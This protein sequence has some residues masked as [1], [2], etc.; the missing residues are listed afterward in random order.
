MALKPNV[1]LKATDKHQLKLVTSPP[2]QAQPGPTEALVHVRATGV[3]G[4]D[5]H[6]WQHGPMQGWPE[7]LH[8]LTI[9]HESGGVV[10]AVGA[11]V[12]DLKVGDHVAIECG[13]PCGEC[14]WC[15]TEQ[16]YNLC[17]KMVFAS[18]MPYEG[19]MQRYSMHDVAVLHKVPASFTFAQIALLEPLG[20]GQ[21]GIT[22]S[23]IRHGEE[24]GCFIVGA[25]AVG[26]AIL[27]L[28]EATKNIRN[29][30][31]ADVS[32]DRLQF[33]KKLAPFVTTTLLSIHDDPRKSAER[34]LQGRTARPRISFDCTGTE[35]GIATAIYATEKAGEVVCVGH[36]RPV[37]TIPFMYL[38]TTEI[39]LH[40]VFRYFNTWPKAIELVAS[41]KID[42]RPL[43]THTFA[44]QDAKA[45]VEVKTLFFTTIS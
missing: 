7:G 5:I 40:F 19:T 20:T 10:V 17:D 4:S 33:A 29:V 13:K 39:D 2:P 8:E 18:D 38:Q 22:R 43:C 9:G 45:A 31:L 28:L 6:F 34:M 36:G 26:M 30:V 37:Q 23:T 3:C 12:K 41:G 14:R 32:E 35:A 27:L 1:A 25:G 44:L 15:T 21:H 16:R 24:T 42:V 11:E